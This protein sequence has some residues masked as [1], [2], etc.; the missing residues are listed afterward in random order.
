M[1]I[2]TSTGGVA[3]ALTRL[4]AADVLQ[5]G[6]SAVIKVNL[7]RPP[8][9]DR[10][11]T[12]PG[13][14][15]AVV[16]FIRS[17]GAS[18]AIAEGAN[19]S[20]ARNIESIGLADLVEEIEVELVDLDL[21]DDIETVTVGDETHYLPTRLRDFACR[22]GIPATTWLPE[23]I[24][25]NNVKLFVGAVPL[26]LYQDGGEDG[27]PGRWR[28]HVELHKSVASIYRA[29][30]H[31]CPFQFFVNGGTAATRTAGTFELPHALVGDDA[32][33]LD[34]RLVAEIGADRPEYLDILQEGTPDYISSGTT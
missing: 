16:S 25:S 7:P 12:H 20:L 14:I 1:I 5:P 29:I 15:R 21:E 17:C 18:C 30:M 31:V 3:E 9:P 23:M 22:I 28:A 11:R 4:G 13:L 2:S 34:N 24:F 6:E 26:R 10:P 33:E 27:R 8:T 32:I 19:G